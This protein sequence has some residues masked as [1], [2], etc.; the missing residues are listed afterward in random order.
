[1]SIPFR[2]VGWR[3]FGCVTSAN[4]LD[5]NAVEGE[6]TVSVFS[7]VSDNIA[8]SPAWGAKLRVF[9]A[10]EWIRRWSRILYADLSRQ[11]R[12]GE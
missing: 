8:A 6:E 3:W 11:L 10:V 5:W 12:V 7:I 9:V 2:S 1:M 4:R